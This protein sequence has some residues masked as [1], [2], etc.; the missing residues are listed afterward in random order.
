VH[1][2]PYGEDALQNVS[3]TKKQ[4]LEKARFG[5]HDRPKLLLAKDHWVQKE[6]A[7]FFNSN[8]WRSL[9]GLRCVHLFLVKRFPIFFG[10]I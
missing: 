6:G 9:A 10:T 4:A 5:P 3:E 8:R 2:C 7:D 1:L